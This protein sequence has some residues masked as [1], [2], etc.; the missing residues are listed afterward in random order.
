MDIPF[1]LDETGRIIFTL[2]EGLEFGQIELDGLPVTGYFTP[3][4]P[5]FEWQLRPYLIVGKV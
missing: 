4:D 3:A 5:D 1:A 2:P